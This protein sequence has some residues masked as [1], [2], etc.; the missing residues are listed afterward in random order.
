HRMNVG[1][2]WVRASLT[3]PLD[4][5]VYQRPALAQDEE[6]VQKAQAPEAKKPLFLLSG[7][8]Q[9]ETLL[10]QLSLKSRANFE[11]VLAQQILSQISHLGIKNLFEKA[12]QL[13]RQDASKFDRLTSLLI[14]YVDTPELMFSTASDLDEEKEKKM[15]EDCIRRIQQTFLKNQA[16]KMALGINKND[17]EKLKE[18]GDI[19]KNRISLNKPEKN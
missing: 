7:A 14:E 9:A 3:T 15:M 13:Y 16:K 19:Y 8:P 2:D 6:P 1:L 18:L 10:M 5:R 17:T 12:E 11:L 4:S